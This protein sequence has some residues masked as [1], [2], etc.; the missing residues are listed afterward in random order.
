[1]QTP[2]PNGKHLLALSGNWQ[3]EIRQ[4]ADNIVLNKFV[5]VGV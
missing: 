5:Q 3:Y 1:M 4:I 2:P